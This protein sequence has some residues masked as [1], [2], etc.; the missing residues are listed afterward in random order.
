MDYKVVYSKNSQKNLSKLQ[1]KLAQRIL[2]KVE[3]YSRLKDPMKM[4]KKLKG[5]S[6]ETFRFRVGDYRVIFRLDPK[7]NKLVVLVVLKI[8]HRKEI[9]S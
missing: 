7:S 6:H 2:K 3:E 5:F 9:Y 8:A 4:A 1:P